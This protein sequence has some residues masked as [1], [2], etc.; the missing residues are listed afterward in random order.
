VAELLRSNLYLVQTAHGSL[1]FGERTHQ[2]IPRFLIRIA[3]RVIYQRLDA[4]HQFRRALLK[5]ADLLLPNELLAG[6][7]EQILQ[8]R[9]IVLRGGAIR[10][11]FVD[12]LQLCLEA[13]HRFLAAFDILDQRLKFADQAFLKAGDP[14]LLFDLPRCAHECVSAKVAQDRT[15][16]KG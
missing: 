13:V 6:A 14:L 9:N 11:A 12:G 8:I 16:G 10:V 3:V 15:G 1:H 7:R 4:L 2:G 5:A